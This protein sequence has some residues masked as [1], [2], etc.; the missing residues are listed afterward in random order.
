MLVYAGIGSR[1]ITEK[2]AALIRAISSKLSEKYIV[3]SGNAGGSDITFQEGSNGKC[4]IYL[5]WSG[6][7]R[8][9]YDPSKSIAHFDVGN[10][11]I[12]RE[13]AAKYHP[14]YGQLKEGAKRL[15]CRNT[16][17]VLGFKDY[18]RA[19]F[20]VFCAKETAEGVQG[21]TAQAIRIARDI[22]LLTFNI[23]YNGSQELRNYLMR[24][25]N[26]NR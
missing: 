24:K 16:H 12:G 21:G 10:T 14:C 20:I 17:Q 7:N 26:E 9:E 4:V 8:E 6:F 18:P 13:Y 15:M 23:R 5:P 25:H 3:Y 22:G 11:D 1:D 2:E 19:E